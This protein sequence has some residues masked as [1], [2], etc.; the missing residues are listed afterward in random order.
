MANYLK[1]YFTENKKID[2][3]ELHDI[4]KECNTLNEIFKEVDKYYNLDQKLGVVSLAVVKGA[5]KQV[6]ETCQIKER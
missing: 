5:V 1:N 4:M 3:L 6:L 2:R